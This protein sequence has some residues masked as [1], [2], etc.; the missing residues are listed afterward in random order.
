[1]NKFW[2]TFGLTY[3]SKVK[4][5][6]FIIFMAIVI[7]LMIALS[8]ADKIMDMFK[9]DGDQIGIVTN[10]EP[11]YKA[12]KQQ[13]NVIDEDAS[14]KK[15][16]KQ[17]AKKQVKN[18]K[19]KEAYIIKVKDKQQLSAT[20]IS[21]ES[22]SQEKEQKVNGVLTSIQSKLVASQLHLNNNDLK[23]LQ[24]QSKVDSQV[25]SDK[26]NQQLNEGQKLLNLV[27]VYAL[28]MLMFFIVFNYATQVAMEIAT[29]KTSRVIE[30]II[31]SV[32]PIT[33]IMA[34]IAGVIAVALTQIIM[35]V[36][37]A[38]IC[39]FAF[40]LKRMLKGF[41]VSMSHIT[42]QVL[43]VGLL[44]MII[45]ILT[46]VLLAAILGSL[47]TR[48]EDINQTLMP[49]TLFAMIAFYIAIF[50]MFKPEILLIKITSFIP[51]LAPFE[52]L[53]RAQSTE[54]QVWEIIVSILIS[55]VVM[56]I[57]LW[58]AVK[59]Y[60]DSVLTFEKGLFNT[61]KKVMKK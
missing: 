28:L 26:K 58:I 55:V 46:Y 32:S 14:F 12:I 50:S 7:I 60:K 22:V 8:N 34:K 9:G 54:L 1:M 35:I 52:L 30:M 31:T 43:I 21:K 23:K 48:I 4:S 57:L 25:L 47:A 42:W 3:K 53:V 37:V 13:G 16:S 51:F 40:D 24:S 49:L 5:K 27:L 29:E 17:E 56:F 19:L 59:T 39:I 44:C 6:S 33:H 15:V 18:E 45:G 41:D 11:I 2:A 10:S 36:V 20:I 61:I 38:I